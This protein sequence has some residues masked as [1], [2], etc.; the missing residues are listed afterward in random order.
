[1][2]TAPFAPSGQR[3]MERMNAVVQGLVL[4]RMK[5]DLGLNGKELVRGGGGGTGLR[6]GR[7]VLK[8]TVVGWRIQEMLEVD[9][10]HCSSVLR[11]NNVY[12]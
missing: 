10:L 4:R 12:A 11:R 7:Y 2:S 5:S 8:V 3:G 1:M 6:V 9:L